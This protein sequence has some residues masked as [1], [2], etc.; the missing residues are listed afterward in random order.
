MNKRKS[1]SPLGPDAGPVVTNG[2]GSRRVTHQDIAQSLGIN[3]STVS[4]ALRSDP[5][6]AVATRKRVAELAEQMGYRPDPALATL[7][8]QRWAG[9]ETGSGSVL[10][11]IVD[12]RYATMPL[13]RRFLDAA[14]KR[15]EQRGYGLLAF[16]LAPYNEIGS[17][18]RVLRARGIRGVLMPQ[19]P[20]SDGPA[21]KEMPVEHFTVVCLGAGYTPVP[22]HAVA[23][24]MFEVTRYV[25]RMI[26]ERGYRRIGGAVFRHS[27]EAL[28][29]AER[30]GSCLAM[31]LASLTTRQ[32]V[33]LLTAGPQDKD[34]FLEWVRRY[35]PEVLLAMVPRVYDWLIEGGWRI[36][37]DIAVAGIVAIPE[38]CPNMSGC[39]R[40]EAEV[41]ATGVDSLIAAMLENEWGPPAVQRR[42]LI[43]PQWYEGT[44]L[45]VKTRAQAG[46]KG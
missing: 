22:F 1:S 29:D 17:A 23:S 37:Q 16:D 33:P 31:Q 8:R 28:D 42:V 45:P 43:A 3:K 24:D 46:T 36:P 4:L 18:M 40:H 11:Y 2:P 14:R 6:I 32:R 20:P 10:A 25:W 15:A 19:L 30:I 9:H 13:Q 41:S 5:R 27:P 26:W 7:A 39:V 21:I 34:A 12:S 35:R 44:S 38:E